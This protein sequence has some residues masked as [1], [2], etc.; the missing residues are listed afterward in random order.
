MKNPVVCIFTKSHRG[1]GEKV[2]ALGMALAIGALTWFAQA[3][4]AEEVAEFAS[5]GGGSP[6]IVYKGFLDCMALSPDGTKLATGGRND[7]GTSDARLW[8]VT[9]GQLIRSF[10]GYREPVMSIAFSPDGMRVVT[11]SGWSDGS[12]RTVRFWDVSTGTAIRTLTHTGGV[13]SVAFS[14]DGKRLLAGAG[15]KVPESNTAK[16]WDADTGSL[17]Q[18]FTGHAGYVSGVA[19]SPDGTR[20]LTMTSW[21]YHDNFH[22][23]ARLWDAATGEL[24]RSFPSKGN[25]RAVG[26]SPDGGRLLAVGGPQVQLW[27]AITGAVVGSFSGHEGDVIVTVAA[28]SPDGT[29][30]LA[31]FSDK[32]AIL[33]DTATY[34]AINTFS[35]DGIVVDVA[36]FPD[37]YRILTR[38]YV[39]G[40][41]TVTIWSV[42]A[43]DDSSDGCGCTCKKSDC[44]L[45]GLRESIGDLFLGGVTLLLLFVFSKR[46]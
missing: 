21:D 44:T 39:D 12:D 36:F 19:F 4:S 14:P 7:D 16:L 30:V 31:G 40:E 38:S 11:G 37:P 42:T 2:A 10:T 41:E 5:K 22:G 27:D 29:R 3:A 33:W 34:E 25:V 8:D 26:F 15:G 1:V 32:T 18:A 13:F 9:T 45:T 46:S 35:H 17:I 24:I 6:V 20:I 23:T 43:Q 28:F